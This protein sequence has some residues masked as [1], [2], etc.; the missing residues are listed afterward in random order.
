MER[1]KPTRPAAALI[2]GCA[3]LIA[4][5]ILF[6]AKSSLSPPQSS[7]RTRRRLFS[8]VKSFSSPETVQLKHQRSAVIAPDELHPWARDLLLPLSSPPDPATETA[9]FWHIPKSGGTSAKSIVQ[10]HG[11]VIHEVSRPE[12]IRRY[13]GAA[14]PVRS[15]Q[16]TSHVIFSSAPEKVI[17]ALF[18]KDHKGRALAMFRHPVDRLVSKFFYL[19][20]A[21]WESTYRP[22]WKGM[23]PL[24]WAQRENSDNNHHVKRLAGKVQRDTATEEDLILAMNTVRERIIVGLMDDMKESFR[25]F[26]KVVGIKGSEMASPW[27]YGVKSNSNSHPKVE[28]GS[29]AWELLAEQNALDIRL[30]EYVVQL[31]D[32]QKD[33]IDSYPTKISGVAKVEENWPKD[34]RNPRIWKS[35]FKE[36]A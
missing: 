22:D 12:S 15:D 14:G 24:V 32:E 18:D 35:K 2:I 26:R 34:T 7:S 19:Q 1:S 30:Y 11:R 4:G 3:V 36:A 28:R 31:F 16:W 17:T 27:C 9:I 23:D 8:I 5:L 25:R 20:I 21:T 13:E 33:I 10:C 6:D 29:P